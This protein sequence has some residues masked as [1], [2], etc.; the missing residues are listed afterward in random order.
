MLIVAS[1]TIGIMLKKLTEWEQHQVES[2]DILNKH[3]VEIF[4]YFKKRNDGLCERDS[5]ADWLQ[6]RVFMF[7]L[8]SMLDYTCYLL[9]CHFSNE[10]RP[11]DCHEKATQCGFPYKYKGVKISEFQ[12]QNNFKKKFIDDSLKIFLGKSDNA[13]LWNSI[14]N[15]IF[16]V[17][18]KEQVDGA[19]NSV[20]RTMEKHLIEVEKSFELL[21][22]F[23]NYSTHRSLVYAVSGEV[24]AEVN[25]KEDSA[26]IVKQ[27]QEREGIQYHRLNKGYWIQ[28]PNERERPLLHVLQQLQELVKEI[29][30]DLLSTAF[31]VDG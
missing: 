3:A 22:Y 5:H 14:G 2:I 7:D 13:N 31:T 27:K 29:T 21:Y 17:Q 18:R 1:M 19:G 11:E 24:W 23:R 20:Q 8:Y 26:K 16:K 9:H 10:G 4:E 15:I 25:I 6:L 12:G 28:V 30:R